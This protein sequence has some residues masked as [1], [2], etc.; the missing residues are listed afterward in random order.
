ML[1]NLLAFAIQSFVGEF[2]GEF[3]CKTFTPINVRELEYYGFASARVPW[4]PWLSKGMAQVVLKIDPQK[5]A[6]K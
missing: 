6:E 3:T 1:E 2:R 5:D 4:K